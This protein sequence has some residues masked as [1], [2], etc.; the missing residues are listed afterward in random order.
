MRA[1]SWLLLAVCALV[2]LAG[3]LLALQEL[4][5][6]QEHRRAVDLAV[7]RERLTGERAEIPPLDL[8]YRDA[9]WVPLG[10]L[11]ALAGVLG[12]VVVVLAMRVRRMRAVAGRLLG[13]LLTGMSALDLAYL[14]DRQW[15]A[16]AEPSLRASIVVLAYPLSAALVAGSV[17]R[18]SQLEPHFGSD[19]P[20]PPLLPRRAS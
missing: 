7:E 3:P 14:F 20:R 1:P 5:R 19:A 8:A 17:V 9:W 15:L 12:T 2:A 11:A 18:L 4:G 13:V 6:D 10:V 16:G